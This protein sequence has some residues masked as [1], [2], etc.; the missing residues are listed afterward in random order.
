MNIL[1]ATLEYLPYPLAG[2]GIYAM[3]LVKFLKNHEITLITPY[4]GMGERYEKKGN[5]EIHRI[6]VKGL[7]FLPSKANRSFID[8]RILFSIALRKYLKEKIDLK[9][10]DFFHCLNA[11]EANFIDYDF[12][13]KYFSVIVSVNEDYIFTSPLNPFKFN[14]TSDFLIRY[15]HH[16]ILKYFNKKSLRKSDKLIANSHSTKKNLIDYCGIKEEKIDIVHRGIDTEKFEIEISKDKYS[17]HKILFIGAN[18]ERKGAIYLVR[19]FPLVLEKY[20]DTTLTLIGSCSYL[21]MKKIKK[22]IEKNKMN[23]KITFI[24]HLEQDKLLSFYKEANVFVMPTL[25]EALGQ[26]YMEAMMTKTPVIGS[27]LGGVPEVISP[28]AGFLVNP[29]DYKEISENIIEIFNDPKK[30]AEIGNKGRER[31]KK[32]FNINKMIKETL[33]VYEKCKK[34]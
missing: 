14:F 12:L 22:E 18:L 23:N 25:N 8:K 5:L 30:A 27:N 9:K 6:D 13:K 11:Q 29:K 24:K 26:V 33:E 15:F 21:Y 7:S 17:N 2:S 19:A 34:K 32:L 1:I 10:Y 3:N 31:I 28:D 16:N 4:H 20:P